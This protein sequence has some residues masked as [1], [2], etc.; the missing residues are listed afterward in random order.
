MFSSSF[1]SILTYQAYDDMQWV[2][3]GWIEA[4]NF[5]QT[6]SELHY[7]VGDQSGTGLQHA[8]DTLPWHGNNWVNAFAHRARVFWNLASVGYDEQLCHG[9]ML[10]NKDQPP[11][12]NAITNELWVASSISMYQ[13][14]PGDNF[15]SPWLAQ[16][17]TDDEFPSKDPIYLAAADEGYTWLK[18][19][20][21]MNEQGLF[22]DGFH[23]NSSIPG[24]VECDVRDEMVYTYNQGV[25]LT[26]HRGLYVTSGSVS[27]LEAGHKLIQAVINATGWSLQNNAPIKTPKTNSSDPLPPWQGLGRGGIMEEE[28]DASGTCSQDGQTFKGIYFHHLTAFCAPLE[29]IPAKSGVTVDERAFDRA[30]TAHATACSAYLGWVAHN[31]KAALTTR[32]DG[33]FGMWWGANVFNNVFVEEDNDGI[34]H[35]A[36]NST[37]YRNKGTPDD[38][39]WGGA[40]GRWEPGMGGSD[41]E[42]LLQTRRANSKRRGSGMASGVRRGSEDPNDRGEGRTVETQV[43]GLAVLRA[44]WELSQLSEPV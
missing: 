42:M 31:A 23:I 36:K 4:I 37:D 19:V 28:C 18:N 29:I 32:V 34:D 33:K 10:W 21:L 13:Y 41:D 8:L 35:S 39:I 38:D 3:L 7:P 17:D 12:K 25:I 11:Y 9:G 27:Y 2:V 40:E 44:H 5:V 1:V 6:H 14:F 26:G 22:A 15:T 16:D 20:G 24:N 43:G 30:K